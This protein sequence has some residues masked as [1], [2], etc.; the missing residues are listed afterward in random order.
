M[1]T[2]TEWTRLRKHEGTERGNW[3]ISLADGV[4]LFR[5]ISSQLGYGYVASFETVAAARAY[6]DQIDATEVAR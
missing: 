4:D 6:A 5:Y 1:T 2:R 3:W